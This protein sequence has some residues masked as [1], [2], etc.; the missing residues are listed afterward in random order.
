MND[1]VITDYNDDR[2]LLELMKETKSDLFQVRVYT[3]DGD[4]W[5]YLRT[6]DS[7][8]YDTPEVLDFYLEDMKRSLLKAFS[9]AG[10]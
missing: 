9:H 5:E 10:T 6:L 8:A 2:S 3:Q 4:V 1:D 7:M